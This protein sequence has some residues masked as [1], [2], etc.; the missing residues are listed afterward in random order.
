VGIVGLLTLGLA[1]VAVRLGIGIPPTDST[2]IAEVAEASVGSTAFALFQAFTALLLLAAA[3]SSFQ[4]GPGLL[5]AL[6]RRSEAD[7]DGSGVLHPRLGTVNPHHTPYWAVAVFVVISAAVV[8]GAQAEDQSLVLFYAVAVFMSFLM[9]LLAMARFSRRRRRWPLLAIN[10]VGAAA[11]ALTLAVN[12]A[13]GYP[14]VSLAAALA[15]AGVLYAAWV[16]A[17]RPG[18]VSEAVE[19]A[20]SSG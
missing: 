6:A 16:R 19:E 12:L 7:G 5:K 10:C 9:G 8:V 2:Q 4:A 17:G 3:S 15:I 14:L 18:G 1:A 20:E 11:V 13:R